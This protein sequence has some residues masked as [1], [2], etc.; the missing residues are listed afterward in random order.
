MWFAVFLQHVWHEDSQIPTT[1]TT[2]NE[3]SLQSHTVAPA[4]C[5]DRA[6]RGFTAYLERNVE[7]AASDTVKL[8]VPQLP[9]CM[10]RAPPPLL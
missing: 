3:A 10:Q 2:Y 8:A 7:Y 1:P 4:D 5:K 9:V 6:P